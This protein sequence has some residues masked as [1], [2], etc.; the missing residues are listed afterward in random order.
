MNRI[1]LALLFVGF[2]AQAEKEDPP[3]NK[4]GRPPSS[5][6]EM[7]FSLGVGALIG[8]NHRVDNQTWP[9]NAKTYVRFI[10]MGEFRYGP[11]SIM[12][13]F[14]SLRLYQSRDW[15]F[16]LKTG[17]AGD[18][19]RG[20]GMEERDWSYFGGA[21]ARY[22]WVE[23]SYMGD[24]QSTSSGNIYSISTGPRFPLS[25]NIFLI[26]SIAATYYDAHYANYYYGV[27][28]EEATLDRPAYS[29][30]R[31]WVYSL[32]LRPLIQLSQRWT[33]MPMVRLSFYSPE[34]TDSPT[35]RD[36]PSIS[37][38]VGITYKIL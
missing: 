12:G 27:R 38:L 34:I 21:S 6:P 23:F 31:A 33:L 5:E 22:K 15:G 13:P 25:K 37:G 30:K 20:L 19:Y 28:A 4:W 7:S 26:T 10:P 36:E 35:V 17:M 16:S 18:Q 11:L 14:V 1:L 8:H 2:F 32:N 29:I 9:Y 24:L 3:I